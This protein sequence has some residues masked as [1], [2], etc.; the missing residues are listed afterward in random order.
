MIKKIYLAGPDVFLSNAIEIGQ[1]KKDL[2][3]KYG[4]EGHFPLD[5]KID[6]CSSPP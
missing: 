4:F 2:C 6:P 1:K 3:K 5:N